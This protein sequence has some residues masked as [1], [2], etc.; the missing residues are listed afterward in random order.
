MRY[1]LYKSVFEAE[2]VRVK[3]LLKG[4]APV[5]GN[6]ETKVSLFGGVRTTHGSASVTHVCIVN[7]VIVERAQMSCCSAEAQFQQAN[8]WLQPTKGTFL[9]G[10]RERAPESRWLLSL[11]DTNVAFHDKSSAQKKW[12]CER[13][14]FEMKGVF[15]VQS[16]AAERAGRRLHLAQWWKLSSRCCYPLSWGGIH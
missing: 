5:L 4:R 14:Q 10:G 3:V 2:D 12:K 1:K 7:W 8:S 15:A 6:V 11:I 16:S 13:V 9:S